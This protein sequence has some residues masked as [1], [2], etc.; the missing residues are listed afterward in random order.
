MGE[1]N[2]K[3]QYVTALLYKQNAEKKQ[4]EEAEKLRKQALVRLSEYGGLID[5]ARQSVEDGN[6]FAAVSLMRNG[7]QWAGAALSDL[8]RAHEA[9]RRDVNPFLVPLNGDRED[10]EVVHLL[11]AGL[12]ICEFTDALPCDWPDG[13]A[14]IGLA[15]YRD[16]FEGD[17]E[18]AR[19]CKGCL[20]KDG[21]R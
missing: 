12:P 9:E 4:D 5:R 11:D 20:D 15:L 19:L 8:E 18:H 3:S 10:D 1:R 16:G 7:F 13:H 17:K 21:D 14:W 6:L 2:Y